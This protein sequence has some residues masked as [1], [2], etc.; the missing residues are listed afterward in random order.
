MHPI[1]CV[2]SVFSSFHR[3][4]L[5]FFYEYTKYKLIIYQHHYQLNLNNL[6]DLEK[7]L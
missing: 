3:G 7:E 2:T 1:C 6:S 4:P 5:N